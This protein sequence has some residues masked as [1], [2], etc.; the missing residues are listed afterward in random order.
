MEIDK[1]LTD[2]F[3]AIRNDYRISSTHIGIFAALLHYRKAKG[4][5][6]P[7]QAFSFEIMEIAKISAPKT[8]SKCVRDL[9]DFGYLRYEPS[10]KK[11]QPSKIYFLV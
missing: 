3:A 11:N 8:Y 7:I 4:F 9:S 1:P 10:F 5:I 6:N 2:F